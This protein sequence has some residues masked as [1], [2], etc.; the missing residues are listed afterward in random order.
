MGDYLTIL[1]KSGLHTETA[2][3]RINPLSPTETNIFFK[4]IH[5]LQYSKINFALR[6]VCITELLSFEVKL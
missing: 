6:L 1:R 5:M 4:Y 2:M 3:D